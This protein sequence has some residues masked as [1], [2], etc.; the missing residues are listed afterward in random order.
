MKLFLSDLD[1]TLIYSHRRQLNGDK[2]LVELYEGRPCSYMTERAQALLR[3]VREKLLFLPCTTR[4]VAQYQRIELLPG[5]QP[6]QALVA[7]GGILL[8]R[9][10]VEPR[11]YAESVA[12]C[13]AAG[14]EL[15]RA[16]QLL[17]Q[18]QLRLLPVKLVDG[19]FLF[20]KSQEPQ[21]LQRQLEQQLDLQQVQ[22]G[23][24]GQKV[25]VLPQSLN[26]G[27]ALQRLRQRYPQ[28]YVYAAGDSAFDVPMLLAADFAIAPEALAEQLLDQRHK[29]LVPAEQQLSDVMLEYLCGQ[30]E[31]TL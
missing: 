6:A 27:A 2:R 20:T 9:G 25:Y 31:A 24:Q 16:Q 11:W 15:E 19:L 23:L 26:K 3:E 13:E 10:Q 12:R 7:N 22:V 18:H 17:E 1:N 28:A 29:L 30:V 5:W 4:S 8:E 21:L 14:R